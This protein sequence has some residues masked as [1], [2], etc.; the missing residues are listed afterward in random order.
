MYKIYGLTDIGNVRTLN[1]DGFVINDVLIDE[2]DYFTDEDAN[3]LTVVCDGMG[4]ESSGEVA[5]FLTLKAFATT[6]NIQ[7]KED[8]KHLIEQTIQEDILRHI[9]KNPQTKG[10]GTTIAG[11]LCREHKITIF[12]VGDSRV[13]R[14]RDDFIRQMTK[15][16]SLVQTLYDS[17]QISFEEKRTHPDRN[18]LLRSLGQKN[19]KVEFLELPSLTEVGDVYL[20]CTDGLTEYV[21]EDELERFLRESKPVDQLAQELVQLAIDRGGADNITVILIKREE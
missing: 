15:D 13:Y 20:L 10:M 5:S 17:G 3:F 8:I 11:V 21:S 19:V 16:H 1:E 12:H 9:E 18:I 7:S 2:G 14:F 6:E 4:G